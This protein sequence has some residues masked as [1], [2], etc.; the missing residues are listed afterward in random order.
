MRPSF[1]RTFRPKRAQATLKGGRREDRVRAAP[2]VSCAKVQTKN[3]HEHTGSAETLRPSP[4]NGFNRYF[5]LSPAIGLSCHRRL[6]DIGTFARLGSRTS[7]RLDA[8]VEASGPHDF[9][10]RK[11]HR[12]SVRVARRSRETRPATAFARSMHPRPPH[13][14]PTSVTTAIRPSCGTGCRS[15]S[16]IFISEKQK[17]F[18]AKGWTGVSRVRALICPSGNWIDSFSVV[19]PGRCEASSPESPLFAQAERG[20]LH[21]VFFGGYRFFHPP[22]CPGA[23]P[24]DLGVGPNSGPDWRESVGWKIL[25]PVAGPVLGPDSSG[26]RGLLRPGR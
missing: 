15:Y 12:S 10:V 24:L 6:A 9:T 21:C 25:L 20:A 13:P 11:P 17:Y 16:L 22:R 4:R 3:A 26:F 7:A 1:A 2:A 8:G 5:V 18:C 14:A 23:P 19:I